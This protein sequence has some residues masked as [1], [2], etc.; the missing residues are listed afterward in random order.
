MA[1][2]KRDLKAYS[3]FDG[4]GRIVPGSTV[5]RRNKPK[6]GN[7]KEVQAYECCDGGGGCDFPPLLFSETVTSGFP[8]NTANGCFPTCIF[9]STC[10]NTFVSD[11]RSFISLTTLAN[12][13]L[14]EF[15]DDLN[16]YFSWAATWTLDGTVVTAELSGYVA[17]ALCPDGEITMNI[18]TVC[19]A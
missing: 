6:N 5:L 12:Y 4:T 18:S 16:Q 7:W 3:R 17:K 8:V 13:T 15:I 11:V 9:E 10:G 14:E 1:T 19:P 2:N